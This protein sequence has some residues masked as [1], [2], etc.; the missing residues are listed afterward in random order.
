LASTGFTNPTK[1]TLVVG[2]GENS[3]LVYLK[4]QRGKRMTKKLSPAEEYELNFLRKQV[5]HYETKVFEL[6]RHK[7]VAR[8]HERAREELKSYVLKLRGLGREV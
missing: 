8:D 7:D 5:D 3:R 4:N 6:E 1:N 2:F